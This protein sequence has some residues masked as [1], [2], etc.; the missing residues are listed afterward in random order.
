MRENRDMVKRTTPKR[1]SFRT[2]LRKAGPP[3]ALLTVGAFFGAY[4]IIGPNGALAYGDIEK[5][6]ERKRTELALLTKQREVL[7]NRVALLDPKNADPDMV[8]ELVRKDLNVAHPD[9]VIVP[10]K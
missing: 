8:D 6:L 3:A 10:L 4:A 1:T 7:K 2:V 9:E 5:H